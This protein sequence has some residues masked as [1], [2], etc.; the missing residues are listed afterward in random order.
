MSPSPPLGRI[1]FYLL[2]PQILQIL[3]GPIEHIKENL[4]GQPTATIS[5]IHTF[6]QGK[7][8]AFGALGFQQASLSTRTDMFCFPTAAP[9]KPKVLQ[10]AQERPKI[11]PGQPNRKFDWTHF[12]VL[13]KLQRGMS[14]RNGWGLGGWVHTSVGPH[15]REGLPLPTPAH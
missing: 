15:G 12:C 1:H 8:R 10:H 9:N 4:F 6:L 13:N 11:P 3:P 2:V 7:T 5:R 14:V